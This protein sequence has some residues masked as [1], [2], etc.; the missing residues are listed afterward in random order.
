[1]ASRDHPYMQ[2]NHAETH[3]VALTEPATYIHSRH[4]SDQPLAHHSLKAHNSVNIGNSAKQ[5][6]PNYSPDFWLQNGIG[7]I[8]RAL[9]WKNPSR[10]DGP[11][12]NPLTQLTF[13]GQKDCAGEGFEPQDLRRQQTKLAVVVDKQALLTIELT[14]LGHVSL[15]PTTTIAVCPPWVV[16]AKRCAPLRN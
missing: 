12:T 1:M 4:L 2:L 8:A 13:V 7:I 9:H 11:I 15:P 16:S 14:S 5:I 10:P 6:A 3:L